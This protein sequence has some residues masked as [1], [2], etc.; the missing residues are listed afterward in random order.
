MHERAFRN[1]P[2]T[3]DLTSNGPI[4]KEHEDAPT[5]ARSTQ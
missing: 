4:D 1:R 5:S 2:F 3:F